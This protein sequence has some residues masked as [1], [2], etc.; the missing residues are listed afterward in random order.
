MVQLRTNAMNIQHPI[1]LYIKHLQNITK[2]HNTLSIQALNSLVACHHYITVVIIRL[3]TDF[4]INITLV[5]I[6]HL[7]HKLLAF[8]CL[9]VND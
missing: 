8:V 9:M 5:Y 3:N 2:H 1:P 7:H 4:D 6:S